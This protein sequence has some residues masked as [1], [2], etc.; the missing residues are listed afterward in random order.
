MLYFPKWK[1]WLAIFVCIM[2]SFIALPNFTKISNIND[3]F[4]WLPNKTLN[5]GLDLK[6]GSQLLLKVD[7]DSYLNDQFNILIDTIRSTLRE[8]Q[9]GY[10]RLRNEDK[11]IIFNLRNIAQKD[12]VEKI[13]SNLIAE[14]NIDNKEDQ[15]E[16]SYNENF[17]RDLKSKVIE[18]SI[19]IVRRRIDET[20][21][22]EPSIQ[23][24][25][26]EYILLQVPGLENPAHLK[27]M[28]GKTAKLT[29]QMVDETISPAQGA[30]SVLPTNVE[31]LPYEKGKEHISGFVVKKKVVLSGDV[32]TN[33]KT[34]LT[35]HNK[36]AVSISLNALGTKQFADLTRE[37]V[38]KAL[39]IILDRKII[40]VATINE[41]IPSGSSVISGNFTLESANDLSLLLRAGALPAPISIEEERV[42]GPN[43]GS[44]SIEAGKAASFFS[45]IM[46]MIF[47]ILTYGIAGLFANIAM[48]MNLIIIIA[49]LSLLQAT[50]TMPGIAGMILT[51]GMAVD[52][53][54]LIFERI[55]E[56]LKL[57]SSVSAAT[58]KGFKQAFATILD[59]NLTTIIVAF[60]LY[61][62]GSGAIKGFAVTLTIGIISSMFSA[63]T[64]TKLMMIGWIKT[65]KPKKLI[66]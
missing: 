53:N 65:T 6:G 34:I 38:G 52:A 47:M 64:L 3:K 31:F 36:P 40:S 7:F 28:L 42:V 19:E 46:V 56:E 14:V 11:K 17:L 9:I 24:Q 48:L 41:P 23:R 29:F 15:I 8:K 4:S 21:T 45:A 51:M 20:G 1:K 26:E 59:S 32:L 2:A 54:V 37:N 33:A 27:S 55:R 10:I 49:C 44:D 18:Q 43:L 5:L 63:I 13:L 60:L 30:N 22:R 12:E 61:N 62:F 39:A 16:V 35:E 66:I 50:L 58:D 25:G 57:G